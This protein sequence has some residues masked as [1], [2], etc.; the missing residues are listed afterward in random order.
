MKKRV[1][2]V[3]V[4]ALMVSAAASAEGNG[5]NW[6]AGLDDDY[7]MAP[8]VSLVAGHMSFDD[9]SGSIAGIEL[10]FNCPLLQPPTNKIRQQLSVVQYD[11]PG[12]EVTSIEINPHYVAEVSPGLFLGGGPG[13][14]YMS[15]DTAGGDDSVLGIQLGGSV[16]YSVSDTFFLGGE[17]RYQ[18]TQDAEFGNAKVEM[19]NWRV[20]LKAGVSF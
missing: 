7:V 3:A 4:S 10:S 15:V 19:D 20:A 18:I 1:L 16:H 9:D 17:A 6:F 12:L 8:T 5:W 13:L 11:E 14:G 2:A